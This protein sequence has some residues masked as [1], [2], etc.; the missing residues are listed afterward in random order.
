M[1]GPQKATTRANYSTRP[2]NMR[3]RR[4]VVELPPNEVIPN[5]DCHPE[6]N[7]LCGSTQTVEV[8]GKPTTL[9]LFSHS[10]AEDEDDDDK[11]GL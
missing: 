9:S 7:K 10:F 5:H 3:W 2:Q 6:N 1:N 8:Y 4:T 11:G